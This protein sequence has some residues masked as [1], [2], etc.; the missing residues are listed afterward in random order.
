MALFPGSPADALNAAR[1]MRV[2]LARFNKKREERG[3]APVGMGIGLNR[4]PLML[5]T[6][7]TADRMDTTVIGDTVNLAARLEGL[8]RTY[9]AEIIISDGIAREIVSG[10]NSNDSGFR[11]REIDL[12]RVKGKTEP[13]VIHEV[14]DGDAPEVMRGKENSREDLAAGLEAYRGGD[15]TEA[16]ERFRACARELPGDNVAA[17][18]IR[19]CEYYIEKP[20]TRWSGITGLKTK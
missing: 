5:G 17:L 3:E 19:R 13:A 2:A 6:V 14:F 1:D 12:V 10:A 9:G 7:G 16:L 15:F 20:P 11:V 8:T 4:G 18:Y